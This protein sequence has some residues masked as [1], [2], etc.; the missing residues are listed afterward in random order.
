[1]ITV[2]A[3]IKA[4]PGKEKEIEKALAAMIP[5]VESEEGTLEYVLHRA[6]NDPLKFLVY[7]KYRDQEAF[8][9]HSSTPAIKELFKT[10]GPLIDGS[11][12]I[13]MYE[14]ITSKK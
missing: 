3:T 9:F 12:S 14:I 1:M 8:S 13:E 10:V 11:P 2:V 5:Q 7:E 6:Q 4:Q